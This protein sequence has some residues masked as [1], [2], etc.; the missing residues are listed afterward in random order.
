[1]ERLF[2]VTGLIEAGAGVGLLCCPSAT[3]LL[4]AGTP[5]DAVVALLVARVG[6]AGLLALG[7]ANWL[8]RHDERSRAARGLV[9]AMVFYNLA[10]V[11][12]LG[13][14]GIQ[15]PSAGVALWLATA[16]HAVMAA[17]CVSTLRSV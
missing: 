9:S 5:L 6:G 15:L 11:V 14:A 10:A 13:T 16:L 2:V 7:V 8:A 1:M 17:W 12:V 3:V 4:L